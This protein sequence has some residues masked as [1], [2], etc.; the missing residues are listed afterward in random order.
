MAAMRT[1]SP[2]DALPSPRRFAF[3]V[4]PALMVL[5]AVATFRQ[6]G[7]TAGVLV[8]AATTIGAVVMVLGIVA[9]RL[10]A[11]VVR[12]WMAL[13]HLL[14]RVTTPVLFTALW[15][16]AFVPVGILR[17]R[18]GRSPLARDPNAASYWVTR[19]ARDE[20]VARAAMERQF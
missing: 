1:T 20:A 9:P 7:G 5:A 17:R 14:G 13:G 15:W 2:A 12:V 18:L 8:S 11:P 19:P 3:T 16:L 6:K 4:G 10:L